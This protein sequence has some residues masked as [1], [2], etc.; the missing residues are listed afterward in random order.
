MQTVVG[1]AM[2]RKLCFFV[3]GDS[4]SVAKYFEMLPYVHA[5]T[6]MA[7]LPPNALLGK[8][9][10]H[11]KPSAQPSAP[12]MTG[13][14]CKSPIPRP[15]DSSLLLVYPP[16]SIAVET[17][18]TPLQLS[19]GHIAA[20]YI[21]CHRRLSLLSIFNMS[22]RPT[23]HLEPAAKK[24]GNDR[25]LTKDDPSDEDEVRKLLLGQYYYVASYAT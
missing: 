20:L 15:R 13:I 23:D 22:K 10:Q 18:A 6:Q 1:T 7:K 9:P 4:L 11:G 8:V 14:V 17:Q 16:G 19:E 25:Q 2:Q 3:K 12:P 5:D 21:T 24:R